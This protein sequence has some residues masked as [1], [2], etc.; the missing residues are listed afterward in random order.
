VDDVFIEDAE[1]TPDT[2]CTTDPE[3]TGYSY[4]I[5]GDDLQTVIDWLAAK[6]AQTATQNFQFDLVF[7]GK[8][9]T[10][11]AYKP[12]TLTPKARANQAL[13]KWTNHSFKHTNLDSVSYRVAARTIRKNNAMAVKLRLDQYSTENMVTPDVSGLTNPGFLQAAFDL[14]IR[15]LVTD[16]SRPGY[17]NPSPNAGI[18]N[19]FQPDIL[20]IPRRPTNLFYNVSTPDEWAAEYN[21][22]YRDFWGQDLT[23][24]EILDEES[25]AIVGYLLKGDLDPLM[26]HEINLRS[27]QDASGEN[28]FLLGELLDAVFTKYNNFYSL[29]ILSPTMDE[30]GRRMA[31]RIAYNQAS[32]TATITP[33]LSITITAQQP[34]TVPVTGL[35]SAGAQTY[36][37]QPITYVDVEAGQSITLPIP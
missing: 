19:S 11:R 7:N 9:A 10:R 18:Y 23:F 1:W 12:D 29:P 34:V 15:Y 3:L 4:R 30:I 35:A 14:G 20:M 21:C 28:C 36:G 13:F 5:T 33:G 2:P 6:Q 22:I 16:T 32:V 25:D 31:Q 24:D 8:G 17:D 27:Y 37:G 26:F